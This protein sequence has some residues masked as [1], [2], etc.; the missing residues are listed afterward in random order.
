MKT[1]NQ[2]LTFALLGFVA[3]VAYSVWK[4]TSAAGAAVA[5]AANAWTPG[6]IAASTLAAVVS[7]KILPFTFILI[8]IASRRLSVS[9]AAAIGDPETQ[10]SF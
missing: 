5:N 8:S 2:L 9:C 6:G 10:K 4:K 1:L 3:Y 7:R